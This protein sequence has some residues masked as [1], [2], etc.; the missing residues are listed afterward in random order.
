ME[1]TVVHVATTDVSLHRALKS[2]LTRTDR[3]KVSA[4][5][6]AVGEA[7]EGDIV[8]TTVSACP[9]EQCAELARRGVVVIVLAAIPRQTE[10]DQ[11]R[12]GGAAAYIAMTVD[13]E[14]LLREVRSAA[15]RLQGVVLE[16]PAIV[17]SESPAPP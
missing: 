9:V 5:E 13:S 10:A 3:F 7:A 14:E 8:V 15:S 1:S 16:A 4:F 2:R 17:A 12:A 11:Y 6:G